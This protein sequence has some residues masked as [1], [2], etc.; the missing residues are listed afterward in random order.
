MATT[1][2]IRVSYVI[3]KLPRAG[4]QIHLAQLIAGLD[5]SCFSPN[6]YCLRRGGSV[7]DALREQGVEVDELGI[8]SIYAPKAWIA[9]YRL[10]ARLRRRRTQ[11]VHTYLVS[12]NIF[13]SVAARLAR[14]PVKITSRRDTGFSRNWRL[15]LVEETL[16]NPFVSCVTA[17]SSAAAEAALSERG[18]SAD[19][20]VTIPNGIDVRRWKPKGQLRDSARARWGIGRDTP[21]L[22]MIGSLSPVKGHR[23]LLRAFRSVLGEHAEARLFLVGD[24]VLREELERLAAELGIT[25]RV[26]FT[27]VRSDIGPILAMLDIS[28]LSSLTEGLSNAILESMAMARPVV[29]TAVGGNLGVVEDGVT[30]LLVPPGDSEALGHAVVRLLNDPPLARSMGEAGRRRVEK[31]FGLDRM[32]AGYE[33]LYRSLLE[34]RDLGRRG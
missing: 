32:V 28:V 9:L 25:S 33:R 20:L 23:D 1:T 22:G 19:R 15:R 7:A 11:I 2:Q 26:V 18:L 10:A 29:A 4:A 5:R 12:S 34:D 24:G 16:V 6:V 21:A 17:V 30:G 14:V 8:E 3:D 31:H 27:G 13:G